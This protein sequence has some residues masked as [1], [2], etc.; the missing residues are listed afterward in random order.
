MFDP[1]QLN[2]LQVVRI[3]FNELHEMLV[4]RCTQRWS[5][6]FKQSFIGLVSIFLLRLPRWTFLCRDM[7]P[8]SLILE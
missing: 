4:A 8:L 7:H 2:R 6:A 1:G 5:H 3:L